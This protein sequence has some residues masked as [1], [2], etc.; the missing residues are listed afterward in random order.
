MSAT[1]N[2]FLLAEPAGSVLGQLGFWDEVLIVGCVLAVLLGMRAR[3]TFSTGWSVPGC[4]LASGSS[5]S[6]SR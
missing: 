5:S 3:S 4:F 1:A 2:I 6:S